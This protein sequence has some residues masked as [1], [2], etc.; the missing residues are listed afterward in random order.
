MMKDRRKN[1]ENK[2]SVLEFHKER[3]EERKVRVKFKEI[4][5]EN[6]P[7]LRNVS[8]QIKVNECPAV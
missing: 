4:I 1:K 3:K 6:F 8:F 2:R 7:E 5:Q